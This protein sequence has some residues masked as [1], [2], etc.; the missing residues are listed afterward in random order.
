MR[1]LAFALDT[2]AAGRHHHNEA[3]MPELAEPPGNLV[4]VGIELLRG[5][6]LRQ[7]DSAIVVR[8]HAVTPLQGGIERS[9][10]M[11]HGAPCSG[12]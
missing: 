4:V 12:I 9:S 8:F 3:E 5:V 7:E 2:Q 11:R 1:R 6:A 10:T